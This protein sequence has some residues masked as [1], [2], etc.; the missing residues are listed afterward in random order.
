GKGVENNCKSLAIS[1]ILR[2]FSR[3]LI[4]NE[5]DEI[6]EQVMKKLGDQFGAKLR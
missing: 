2:H 1:L 5:V 3:T 6:V 4:D